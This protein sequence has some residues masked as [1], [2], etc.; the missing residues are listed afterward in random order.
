ML[1]DAIRT[2]QGKPGSKLRII[3]IGTVSPAEPGSWWADLVARGSR[4]SL[5]VMARQGDRAKWDSWHEIRKANPLVEIDAGFRRK[6]LEER[7]EARTDSRARAA[8][9]SYRLNQPTANEETVLLTVE[10]WERVT[11]RPVPPREGAPVVGIDLAAGRAWSCAS[12]VYENGRVEAMALCPGHSLDPRPG[13]ARQ[14]TLRT[15]PAPC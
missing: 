9:I 14:G 4:G 6:L 15:L 13:S 11:A 3:L 8:F 2:A 10:D 5:Y 7:D 1:W 12:A